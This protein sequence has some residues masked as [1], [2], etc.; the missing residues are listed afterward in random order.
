MGTAQ[1]RALRWIANND[2]IHP[3]LIPGIDDDQ[4]IQRYILAAFYYAVNGNGNSNLSN[5]MSSLPV[6]NSDD[7]TGVNCH[8]NA[9]GS[10]VTGIRLGQKGL[11]GGGLIPEL[12]HLSSLRTLN[13]TDNA[14][15]GT[16][17]TELG[18]LIDL[19]TLDLSTNAL[20]GSIPTELG[21]LDILEKLFLNNN[22]LSD[23]IPTELGSLGSLEEL[24]LQGN[25]LTGDIPTELGQLSL[26]REANFFQNSLVG[27]MP[28]EIC[29]IKSGNARFNILKADCAG[30]PP[31]VLCYRPCC[32]NNSCP[33][34][35]TSSPTVRRGGSA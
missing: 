19:Q 35:P 2:Q 12:G 3:P 32:T 9:G 8:S 10:S 5:W 31:E 25:E 11:T 7:W 1:A 18:G 6:C 24:K 15:A 16:I 28:A 14:L 13:L 17:L 26:L 23:E 22:E 30:N 34:Q 29:S 27:Q 20:T 4:I 21:S 33:A